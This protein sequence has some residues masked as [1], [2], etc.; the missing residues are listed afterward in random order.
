MN[1]LPRWVRYGLWL[2][3]SA[4]SSVAAL[5]LAAWLPTP[6]TLALTFL[7]IALVAAYLLVKIW[8]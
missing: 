4:I 3:L 8:Q 1:Q 2:A 5:F 7:A 6:A